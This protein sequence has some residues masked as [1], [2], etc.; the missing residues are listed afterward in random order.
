MNGNILIPIETSTRILEL[1]YTLEDFWKRRKLQQ[2]LIFLSHQSQSTIVYAKSMLEWMGD[3][4]SQSFQTR[5]QPFDFRYLKCL[6]SLEELEN[7]SGPKVVLASFPSLEFGFA[8]DL[9][10]QWASNESNCIVFPERP[11]VDSI[12][13]NL[14]NQWKTS[15][16]KD[17]P[18]SISLDIPLTIGKKV[19]LEGEEL[20]AYLAEEQKQ[21]DEKEIFLKELDLANLSDSDDEMEEV[22]GENGAPGIPVYDIYVKDHVNRKGFFKQSQAFRMYPVHEVRNRVDEY[23]E[24]LDLA[25]FS[26]FE[27]KV[28]DDNFV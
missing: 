24:L 3:S 23:G 2:H 16:N 5:D 17:A 15:E 20:E 13:W 12:G 14:Y 7:L 9:L 10:I 27:Q 22:V 6:Q 25:A 8:Q 19:P 26:K 1:A 28:P 4:I 18:V 11:P 21:E